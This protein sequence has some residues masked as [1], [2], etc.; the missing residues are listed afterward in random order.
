MSPTFLKGYK[1]SLGLKDLPT[2]TKK[3]N[4]SSILSTFLGN[5]KSNKKEEKKE[6]G[7]KIKTSTLTVLAKSFGGSFALAALLRLLNDILL[8]MT[9]LVFRKIVRAIEDGEEAWKGYMWCGFLLLT[10][11][12]QITI[13]NHYFR[14]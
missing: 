11:T 3:L 2:I 5:Y 7:G 8:Y 14:Q 9:P 12:T 6:E 1:Q 10:A 4:V 13:S